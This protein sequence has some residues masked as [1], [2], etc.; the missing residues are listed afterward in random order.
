M[1]LYKGYIMVIYGIR[2]R[3]PFL[4]SLLLP[5]KRVTYVLGCADL[6]PDKPITGPEKG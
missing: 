2:S 6:S 3:G 5:L 4:G 1:R